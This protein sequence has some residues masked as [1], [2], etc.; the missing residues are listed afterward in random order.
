MR[1]TA[2]YQ[3]SDNPRGFVDA[4]GRRSD[5]QGF[6]CV[7]QHFLDMLRDP[8]F[9][10]QLLV[11]AQAFVQTEMPARRLQHQQQ[12]EAQMGGMRRRS[13]SASK[14]ARLQAV[15]EMGYNYRV[16]GA[17]PGRITDSEVAASLPLAASDDTASP[18]ASQVMDDADYEEEPIYPE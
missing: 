2:L 11:P 4:K 15:G 9:K 17:C 18:S 3:S 7:S 1:S 10:Q 5:K 8:D 16:S 13:T 12:M 14:R 6:A